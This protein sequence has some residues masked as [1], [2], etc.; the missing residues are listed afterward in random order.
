VHDEHHQVIRGIFEAQHD[1]EATF[2]LFHPDIEWEDVSGLWTADWGRPRGIEDV[3][4]KFRRW[5]EIFR[6]VEFTP[7]D[8]TDVGEETLVTVHIKGRARVSE[9]PVEQR[10][11]LLFTVRDGLVAR[12]RAYRDRSAALE[13]AGAGR[14]APPEPLT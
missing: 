3:R 12:V 8:F 2:A 13:A 7:E 11:S 1:V 9:V 10:I 14:P 5:F 4:E 6:D